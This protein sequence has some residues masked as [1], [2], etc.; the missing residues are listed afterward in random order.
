MGWKWFP[1][2]MLLLGPPQASPLVEGAPG[3]LARITPVHVEEPPAQIS[4]IGRAALFDYEWT[5]TEQ[6]HLG[7]T[8]WTVVGHPVEPDSV[9]F[10]KATSVPLVASSFWSAKDAFFKALRTLSDN[11]GCGPVSLD[12]PTLGQV[13]LIDLTPNKTLR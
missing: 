7:R 2:A 10:T 8:V 6:D 4:C 3:K 9:P 11:Q 12:D 5:V 1:F 13:E